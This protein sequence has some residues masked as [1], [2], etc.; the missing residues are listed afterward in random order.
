MKFGLLEY[1]SYIYSMDKHSFKFKNKI[2]ELTDM[3]EET[4]INDSKDFQMEQFNYLL[5]IKDYD[6]MKNRI[7]NQLMLGYLK[8]S[9]YIK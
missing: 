4:C 5:K 1:F 7:I 9:S 8:E 6:T 3:W 2:Y